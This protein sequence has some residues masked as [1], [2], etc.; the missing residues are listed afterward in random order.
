MVVPN[1]AGSQGE[2][3]D[4]SRECEDKAS[5]IRLLRQDLAR[6]GTE[7]SAGETI[8]QLREQVR[9]QVLVR[10]MAAGV[11]CFRF[12]FFCLIIFFSSFFA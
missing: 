4:K 12:L 9:D 2:L 8:A 3:E 5:T 10:S 1:S 6:A 11:C 7:D